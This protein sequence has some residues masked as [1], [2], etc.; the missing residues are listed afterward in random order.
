MPHPATLPEAYEVYYDAALLRILSTSAVSASSLYCSGLFSS[1][2]GWPDPPAERPPIGDPRW[3]DV[4]LH[5]VTGD[6]RG[7]LQPLAQTTLFY[8]SVGATCSLILQFVLF[9]RCRRTL[10]NVLPGI[11]LAQRFPV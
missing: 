11:V 7:F 5:S 8:V 10:H 3:F 1:C 2:F 6:R 9:N 4:E